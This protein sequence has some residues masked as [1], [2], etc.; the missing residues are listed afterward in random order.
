MS[1]PTTINSESGREAIKR[2]FNDLDSLL[3]ELNVQKE[4]IASNPPGTMPGSAP[5]GELVEPVDPMP[6][7]VAA[8]SGKTIANTIDTALGTGMMLYAKSTNPEKYQ[9]TDKQIRNLEQAWAAVAAKYNYRV[10][11]SPWFNVGVLTVA[12]YLPHFQEAKND[13]RFAMMEELIRQEKA[14]REALA[15]RMDKMEKEKQPTA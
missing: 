6:A 2:N 1:L 14:E 7:E 3:D 9:A 13:R 4:E 11:D 15:A 10:E 8:L 5:V 12:T